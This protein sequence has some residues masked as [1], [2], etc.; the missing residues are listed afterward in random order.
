MD[1]V[2]V[3][4]ARLTGEER[5]AVRR[6]GRGPTAAASR[7]RQTEQNGLTFGSEPFC[8][9]HRRRADIAQPLRGRGGLGSPLRCY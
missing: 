3:A 5:V 9:R 4:Y 7:S 6:R 8:A 1:S 2:D